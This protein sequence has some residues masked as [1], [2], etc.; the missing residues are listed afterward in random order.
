MLNLLP[1]IELY[2]ISVYAHVYV[3]VHCVCVID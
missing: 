1:S 2:T 3:H